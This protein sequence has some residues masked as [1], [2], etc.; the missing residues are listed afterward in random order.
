MTASPF[1]THEVFNQTPP[2]G[3][4][5]LWRDDPALQGAVRAFGRVDNELLASL[6]AFGERWGTVEMAE[7]GRLANENPPKLHT[8]DPHGYRADRVEFH[9]AY[10][11]LMRESMAAGIHCSVWGPDGKPSKPGAFVARAA[12]QMMSAEVEQGHQCPIVMTNA[13]TGALVT[14]P[15]LLKEWLPKIRSRDYDASFQPA[16][17]KTSVTL[18]M[19]M[20]EKQ[21]GSD[22]RANT[23][24]AD[25]DGDAYRITGHKWFL[26]AP[27][28]DAFLVLAQANE[29][30]TCFLMPRFQPDG[31]VNAIRLRRL[32]DKLGNRSNASSEVEFQMAYARRCGPEGEGIRTIIGM[33]GLT[34]LDCVIGALGILRAAL[35]QAIHHV[36]FRS[37][38]QKKL[39]DQ[40]LMRAVIADLALEREAALALGFRLARAFDH[41][42]DADETAY[43]RLITPAAKLYVC[44]MAPGFVYECLE[45]MGGNGYI[46]ENPMARLYREAPLNAIWE[47]SGNIMALDVLRGVA[48]EGQGAER[49]LARLMKETESLP[50]AGSAA[51][52]IQKDFAAGNREA[53]ARRA[54]EAL[55]ELA[56]AAALASS[57]PP[58]I[59]E[60][61]AARRLSGIAGRNYGDPVPEALADELMNRA[62]ARA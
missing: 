22:V 37:A 27:M 42:N 20:T 24:R 33:V 4:M 53:H 16:D 46:K 7:F 12:R 45:C 48:R 17:M 59:A 38:F 30:L 51:A 34:R 25:P 11:A 21:G 28:S 1:A 35:L 60:M 26:S 10:H 47:G 41:P 54:A 43:A 13:A 31:R 18:G 61:Y 44:K 8:Y 15:A 23:T 52:R 62:F 2:L 9:P 39:V 32:K 49:V 55:A 5:N 40:P 14:E 50:G 56:A 36:R 57:A 6:S 19:G 3:D 58:E 29:G